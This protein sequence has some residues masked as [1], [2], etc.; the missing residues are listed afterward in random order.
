MV[1]L[2]QPRQVALLEVGVGPA[3]ERVDDQRVLHVDEH[4][5]RR[6]DARQRF[7]GQHGVEQRGAGAAVFLG[8]LDAHDAEVEELRQQRRRH[9]GVFVHLAHERPHL[10]VGELVDAVGEEAFVVGQLGQGERRGGGRVGHGH[11]RFREGRHRRG[12]WSRCGPRLCSRCYHR[13]SAPASSPRGV[14]TMLSSS[15]RLAVA[16][17]C[18]VSVAGCGGRRRAAG[19]TDAAASRS[20]APQPAAQAPATPPAEAEQPVFRGRRQLRA[21]RCHRHRQAGQSGHRSH[22]G[23]LRGH[24]RRQ[25]PDH[26]DV[27]SGED[28]HHR[29]GRDDR[30]AHHPPG[31]R[32]RRRRRRRAHLRLLP[33]RIS[34]AARQ[35]HGRA[36]APHRLRADAARAE[37]SGVG[38]VSAQPARQ[39]RADAQP[40]TARARHRTLPGPQVRLHAA[41]RAR[42]PLRESADR[43]GRA[44]PPA[45]VA[46][47]AR[48]GCR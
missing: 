44:H 37:G 47:G 38:D 25:A 41:Q 14:P 18:A 11:L 33:R 4:A 26:R 2:G 20:A 46:L 21:R 23:R 13:A 1:V 10:A 40:R 43:S 6:V 35:Q 19:R 16:T 48:P 42:R 17:V 9:L 30:P 29:A 34:R 45:G 24:R 32:E 36:Q 7:D 31:R 28:R 27:P 5:E 12:D 8:N 22:P 39:R 3:H 15:V